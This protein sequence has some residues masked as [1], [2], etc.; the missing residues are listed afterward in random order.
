MT[1]SNYAKH[2][3]EKI[4]SEGNFECVERFAI[5]EEI[6][7]NIEKATVRLN[8]HLRSAYPHLVHK[9]DEI[10]ARHYTLHKLSKHY[11]DLSSKGQ[12]D[13]KHEDMI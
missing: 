13:M 6:D 8:Y 3:L 12:I 2:L 11:K 4:V 1:C 7:S 5:I 10:A 9:A